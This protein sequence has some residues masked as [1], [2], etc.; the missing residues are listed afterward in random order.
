MPVARL[1]AKTGVDETRI[2][3]T[4]RRISSRISFALGEHD[5]LSRLP[6]TALQTREDYRSLEAALNQLSLD[7]L[8]L[9]T[10]IADRSFLEDKSLVG[11]DLAQLDSALSSGISN[12]KALTGAAPAG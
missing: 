11:Q 3:K 1:T 8:D 9:Q 2:E 10:R 6:D 4:A 12:A 5:R 7:N